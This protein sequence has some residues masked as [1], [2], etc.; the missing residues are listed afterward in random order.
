VNTL[1]PDFIFLTGDY[2]SRFRTRSI[3]ERN[4]SALSRALK[5][6]KA[7]KGI[8]AVLG[9]NDICGKQLVLD[10]FQKAGIKFSRNESISV[11]KVAITGI[12]S[13]KTLSTAETRIKKLKIIGGDI[14]ILLSHEPDTA[15]YS[16]DFFDLQLSGHTHGG[17][18]VVPFGIGPIITPSMGKH[19]A[20]GLYKI[21][22]MML[23][24][25]SG[26]GISP[27]PKPLVRFSN[28]P[29]ISVLKI[30]PK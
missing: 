11:S 5:T 29:E 16:S 20:L 27:L 22:S 9:N 26:I 8:F 2:I 28:F 6:L 10:A 14:R 3:S 24:V 23:Y 15:L 19:F 7:K 4:T 30:E 25:S 18:C 13:C 17:Q 21:R 1:E 12:D